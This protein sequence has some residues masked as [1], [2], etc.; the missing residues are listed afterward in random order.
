[1]N[2][3]SLQQTCYP[4]L[5]SWYKPCLYYAVL[6]SLFCTMGNADASILTTRHNLSTSGPGPIKA[7][8]ET[9]V[10]V[11]CH[12]PHHADSSG[13]LWNH[14]LSPVANYTVPS[15]ATQLSS[16]LIQPDGTSRLC[17]SCHDGT[18]AIGSVINIGGAVTTISMQ[19]SGTGRLTAGGQLSAN[20]PTNFSTDLSGHHPVSIEVNDALLTD[21][22]KQCTDGVITI[23]VCNPA[24]PIKLL[25]TAN[26]Y[27]SGPH[28]NRGVQ[29]ASCHDPHED[30]V[31]GTTMFLRVAQSDL[32][33]N[34]HV[35]CAQAC[36]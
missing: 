17:L 25:T 27:V 14:S 6:L 16:P 5:A 26:L 31:P 15:S 34:C 19:D 7:V 28:T 33:A 24:S 4:P 13:P 9:Q 2:K 20:I 18:V 36:P 10:C 21:K 12:T 8:S 3:N 22:Q 23:K 35:P 29:C 30:P 1:M 11:F 32:C